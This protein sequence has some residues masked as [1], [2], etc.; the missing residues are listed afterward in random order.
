MV[1]SRNLNSYTVRNLI[2]NR[3][4]VR[5]GRH[6]KKLVLSKE[7][8][9]LLKKQHFAI[10]NDNTISPIS[11]EVKNEGAIGIEGI[12]NSK[13]KNQVQSKYFLRKRS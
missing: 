6:L 8:S 12:I 9:E 10:K 11:E 13:N 4:F 5:N 7:N 3:P 2:D 1:E